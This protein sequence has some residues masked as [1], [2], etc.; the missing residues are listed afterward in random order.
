MLSLGGPTFKKKTWGKHQQAS[1]FV[2]HLLWSFQLSWKYCWLLSWGYGLSLC[3]G[4]SAGNPR[5]WSIVSCNF[6]ETILRKFFWPD[7]ITQ[8]LGHQYSRVPSRKSRTWKSYI[9]LILLLQII[10]FQIIGN[11]TTS[12]DYHQNIDLM[13][14]FPLNSSEQLFIFDV[15]IIQ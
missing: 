4:L 14:S 3:V 5:V 9:E 10:V 6:F 11:F 1:W 12:N 13:N 8:F 2:P 15:I 7:D